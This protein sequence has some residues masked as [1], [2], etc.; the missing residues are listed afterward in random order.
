MHIEASIANTTAIVR[1]RGRGDAG[2]TSRLGIGV[3]RRGPSRPVGRPLSRQPHHKCKDG[4]LYSTT[5]F[6]QSQYRIKC[7][8]IS[9]KAWTVRKVTLQRHGG[10]D[11]L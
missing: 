6:N 5:S 11:T 7:Q 4:L 2:D 1:Q 3:S 9:I 10:A 8:A